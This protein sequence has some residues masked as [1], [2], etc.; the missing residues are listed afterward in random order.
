MFIMDIKIGDSVAFI[1]SVASTGKSFSYVGVV[2][3]ISNHNPRYCVSWNDG[4]ETYEDSPEIAN[5][6][7]QYLDFLNK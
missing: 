2:S 6:R 5:F 4:T 3:K 7:K 1:G